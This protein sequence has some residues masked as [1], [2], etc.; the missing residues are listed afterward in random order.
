MARR[1][2]GHNGGHV[3]TIR[4]S[5]AAGIAV[6][7]FDGIGHVGRWV[8][9]LYGREQRV[10]EG[11]RCGVLGVGFLRRAPRGLRFLRDGGWCWQH[12]DRISACGYLRIEAAADQGRT[13]IAH[14][15]AVGG[16]LGLGPV[17]RNAIAFTTGAQIS[18]RL[19]KFERRRQRRP[20]LGATCQE[21]AE[22]GRRDEPSMMYFHAEKERVSEAARASRSR[23]HLFH[24]PTTC[25]W[26]PHADKSVRATRTHPT[27]SRTPSRKTL[28]W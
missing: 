17:Q 15:L 10:G 28:L 18:R 4:Q 11:L 27:S 19:R 8:L 5:C 9:L 12:R 14:T 7:D 25:L 2:H 13:D 22:R 16:A 23:P 24:V 6:Q 26:C 1:R 20:G 3:H 21:Q